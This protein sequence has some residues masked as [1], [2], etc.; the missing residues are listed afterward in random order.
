[1]CRSGTGTSFTVG[2]PRKPLS[3][4]VDSLGQTHWIGLMRDIIRARS[5]KASE[6]S[7]LPWHAANNGCFTG[8]YAGPD[9]GAWLARQYLPTC[10]R[11]VNGHN[12]GTPYDHTSI[13]AT[14]RDWFGIPAQSMLP[15]A[16]IAQAPTLD[17]IL[18]L[19]APRTDLPNIAAPIGMHIQTALSE[20]PN[21]LQKSL[22]AA[23]TRRFGLDPAAAVAST[24][25]R[26][27]RPGGGTQATTF[28]SPAACSRIRRASSR[29]NCW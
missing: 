27:F 13:L 28:C 21:D 3:S 9:F 4:W 11:G 22:V 5:P 8:R 24:P 14:L 15:S 1:M 7:M 29:R 10:L 2:A 20:P 23:S 26:R 19:S 16:R 6:K 25:T 17:G 18:T 12:P